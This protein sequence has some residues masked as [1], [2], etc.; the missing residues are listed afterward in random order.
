MRAC[1]FLGA[2]EV[3]SRLMEYGIQRIVAMLLVISGRLMHEVYSITGGREV[4]EHINSML[5]IGSRKDH[6]RAQVEDLRASFDNLNTPVDS[7]QDFIGTHF[8]LRAA[9]AELL[10]KILKL[11]EDANRLEDEVVSFWE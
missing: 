5:A 3:D 9:S 2:F 7:E 1:A 11:E 8:H 4:R 6:L 10:A